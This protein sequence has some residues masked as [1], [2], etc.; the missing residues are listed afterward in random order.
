[1][2]HGFILSY[3]GCHKSGFIVMESGSPV[4]WFKPGEREKAI[5]FAHQLSLARTFSDLIIEIM[6]YSIISDWPMS[7]GS[8]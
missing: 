6:E 5:L 8:I 4:G 7:K 2:Q 1:M 3:K